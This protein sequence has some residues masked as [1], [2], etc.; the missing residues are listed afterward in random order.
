MKPLAVVFLQQRNN[1]HSVA[2]LAGALESVEDRLGL[3]VWFARPRQVIDRLSQAAAI[4]RQVVLAWSFHTP[5]VLSVAPALRDIRQR[6]A[7]NRWPLLALAG[8]AHPSGDPAGTLRLGF[9]YVLRGE[10]E[11]SLPHFLAALA[12]GGGHRNTPGLGWLDNDAYC[13]NRRPRPVN[14]DLYPPFAVRHS[15]FAPIEISRGCPCHCG[16][17]QTPALLGRRMRH[18]SLDTVVHHAEVMRRHELTDLRF[19]STN[20]FAWGSADGQTP[21]PAGIEALLNALGGI[22]DKGRIYFGSFPSEVRPDSVTLELAAMVRRLAGNDNVVI[23]AQSG[24]DR[25]LERLRRGH[26]VAQVVRAVEILRNAGFRV[27][28]DFIFALP[29]EREED[30]RLTRVLMRR[31]SDLGAI[32]HGHAFLP[33]PGTPLHRAQP[34]RVDA[35]TRQLALELAGSGQHC[36]HWRQQEELAV[37]LN[38]FYREQSPAASDDNSSTAGVE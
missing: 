31:V 17:C 11:A 18:R 24:S 22:F 5:D 16:F 6:A 28:V 34:G 13:Q 27:Y 25:M 36:G 8:G 15:L 26:D 35:E 14:L 19:V 33:L 21:N 7:A 37:R 30:Q 2:A 20:A 23:G 4:H 10:A 9:D 38:R 29:G 12:A 3:T 1:K 32:V